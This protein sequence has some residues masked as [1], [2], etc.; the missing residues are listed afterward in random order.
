MNDNRFERLLTLADQQLHHGDTHGAID[1]LKQLLSYEPDIAEAHAL[2]AI[3][4]FDNKR[5]EAAKHEAAIALRL[6][7]DLGFCHYAQGVILTA[8][9]QF[10]TA[11]DNLNQA[12]QLEPTNATY[13]LAKAN[14]LELTGKTKQVLPILEQAIAIQPE[15]VGCHVAL[16]EY[17]LE[18][19]D[20]QQ[21]QAYATDAM[22]L[23]PDDQ[24]AITLMGSIHLHLGNMQEAKDH[25][26]WALSHNAMAVKPLF[27]MSAI[28]AKQSPWL[29]LWWRFNS[30]MAKIGE[31][32]QILILIS[33]YFLYRLGNQLFSDLEMGNAAIIS[34]FVWLAFCIYS[35]VGPV[36]F[37]RSLAKELQSFSFNKEF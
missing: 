4:L 13:L 10:V 21:A 12:T 24:D 23:D 31:A 32:K 15:L 37:Q 34:T 36:I 18:K 33:L 27:L 8:A 20:Y 9:R 2:L 29:G 25:A 35:W 11:E 7:P 16:G 1:S 30:F 26:L 17:H 5:L 19:G 3:C 22:H 14:L 6:A 28:K